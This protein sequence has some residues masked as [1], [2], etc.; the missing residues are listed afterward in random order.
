MDITKFITQQLSNP[1]TLSLLGQKINAKPSQ[2]KEAAQLGIPTLLQAL[3][4]NTSS[5]QGARSLAKALDDHQDDN[6][7]DIESFLDHLD[8]DDAKKMLK[9]ILADKS[10]R[11]QTNVAKKT[12]LQTDQVSNLMTQLAP[13]LMGAL[14][15]QKREEKVDEN[16]LQ[17]L[18]G[19]LL[20]QG[21][22][23][24]LMGMVSNL[25][26]ADDD[27]NVMDDVGGLLQGF[28]KK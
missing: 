15:K 20:N 9:H 6:I 19:G 23:N 7:D 8:P 21:G 10:D 18:L 24:D 13:L 22:G 27:G 1:K 28:F 25:L 3:T 26:D 16:G 14:A 17:G 4:R 2:V 12:G 5:Q 11:V